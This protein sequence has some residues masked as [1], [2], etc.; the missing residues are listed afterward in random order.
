V[1]GG[2]GASGEEGEDGASVG[3]RGV[4]GAG[5]LRRRA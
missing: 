2:C 3:W 1:G 5:L 4:V